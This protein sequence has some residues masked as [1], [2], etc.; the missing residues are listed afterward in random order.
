MHRSFLS[1]ALASTSLGVAF[2]AETGD[3]G[4]AAAPTS[5]NIVIQGVTFA[6]PL[7]Y[8]AGHVLTEA[9]ARALNQVFHENVR[10]NFAKTVKASQDKA[11]GAVAEADLPK[12]FTDYVTAYS[13]AMPGQG[14]GSRTLDPIEKEARVI[15][16]SIVQAKLAEQGKSL[17]PPKNASEEE[18]ATYKA[19]I[20]AKI[21]SVSE[22][23]EILAAAKAN[24]DQRAKSLS[25][26]SAGL[27]L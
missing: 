3:A 20:D 10:N 21:E 17:T 24:V 16:R 6:A 25:K 4:G 26:I 14:G 13:F 9:E 27:E 8:G 2:A 5:K 22:R 1:L 23:P 15:A 19:A 7:P 11:D 12:A 18:K